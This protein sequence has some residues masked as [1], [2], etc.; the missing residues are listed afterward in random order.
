M[1]ALAKKKLPPLHKISVPL[2]PPPPPPP[3]P[4][5]TPTPPPSSPMDRV[6]GVEGGGRES[7]GRGVAGEEEEVLAVVAAELREL[8]RRRVLMPP[9]DRDR[10]ASAPVAAAQGVRGPRT[11]EKGGEA[12]RVAQMAGEWDLGSLSLLAWTCAIV[13]ASD[14]EL[15]LIVE[16][17]VLQRVAAL[18]PVS[19]HESALSTLNPSSARHSNS[20]AETS[21][22]CFRS[23]LEHL[24]MLV[25]A[26]I[27]SGRADTAYLSCLTPR[28]LG[29]LHLCSFESL[30]QLAQ[31]VLATTTKL[32]RQAALNDSSSLF[33]KLRAELV[34]RRHAA[35]AVSAGG[36]ARG[37]GLAAARKPDKP[38]SSG[39]H[40]AVSATLNVL[41][42]QYRLEEP[43]LEGAFYIDIVIPHTS[44]KPR[45]H[46]GEPGQPSPAAALPP[47]PESASVT[48]DA[49]VS[50]SSS[51]SSSS[52]DA[53]MI[54]VEVDGPSHFVDVSM[55]PD[56]PG[57]GVGCLACFGCCACCACFGCCACFACFGCLGSSAGS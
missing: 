27:A 7:A 54:A 36:G 42:V 35:A 30:T 50:S 9:L 45:P 25:W 44:P 2:P 23:R 33:Y 14:P 47:H 11:A 19:A 1:H 40:R 3:P 26:H 37:T 5:S 41:G 17:L 48:A 53:G 20:G 16:R 22:A 31:M 57:P 8:E 56:P 15:F 10:A 13:E 51:S 28:I 6:R 24:S 12:A 29:A 49:S 18:P 32:E 52:S 55:L 38:V 46:T 34:A 43:V 21:G 4:P 39:L